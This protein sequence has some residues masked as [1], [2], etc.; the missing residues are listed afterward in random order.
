MSWDIDV[1]L[2]FENWWIFMGNFRNY[3]ALEHTPF[4]DF[5]VGGT[6]GV[7]GMFKSFWIIYIYMLHVFL[8]G[9]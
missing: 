6:W 8:L 2:G 4:F 1:G 3:R 7:R 5:G 9:I